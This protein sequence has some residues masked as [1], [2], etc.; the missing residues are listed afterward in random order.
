M[1]GSLPSLAARLAAAAVALSVLSGCTSAGAPACTDAPVF[2]V[3]NTTATT[4]APGTPREWDDL[5]GVVLSARPV[6]ADIGDNSWATFAPHAGATTYATFLTT[7]GTERAPN[8]W[9]LWSDAAPINTGTLL[10]AVW[11]G[12]FT[13]GRPA[14][15]KASGGTYSMGIAYLDG[16]SLESAKVTTTYL[17]TVTI[18]AS[19]GEWTFAD[20][21]ACPAN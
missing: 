2:L 9:R 12:N 19:T 7:P 11:P 3:D 16:S 20:A 17:T 8:S 6:P 18:A 14:P 1:T 10:P 13:Y 5:N 4:I 21:P 15:I